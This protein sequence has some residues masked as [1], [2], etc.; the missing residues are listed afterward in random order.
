MRLGWLLNP[1]DQQ[2]ES[3]RLGQDKQV[4]SLPTQ[5]SGK[6]VLP[7]F[8]LDLPRFYQVRR[9]QEDERIVSPTFPELELTVEQVLRAGR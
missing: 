7:G 6:N 8:I 3:Y 9:F 1:Q 2:V 5:L 4:R